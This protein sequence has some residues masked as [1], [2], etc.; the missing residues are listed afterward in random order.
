M[1]VRAAVLAFVMAIGFI[2]V[3]VVADDSVAD[4]QYDEHWCYGDIVYFEY[5]VVGSQAEV[6]WT[7][8]DLD[9]NII[10]VERGISVSFDASEYDI[11]YVEQLVELNGHSTIKTDKVNLMHVNDEVSAGGDGLFT[12]AFFDE[13]GGNLVTVAQFME[14]SVVHA[15]SGQSPLFIDEMPEDPALEGRSFQGWYYADGD[16]Q[17]RA[18]DPTDPVISDMEVYAKWTSSGS[19][20][21]GGSGGTVV[22]GGTHIVTFECAQGLT[23]NVVS[24]GSSSVSFTVSVADGYDLIGDVSVTSTGGTVTHTADGQY[25]LSGISSNIVVS[26][27]GNTVLVDDDIT[28][29]NPDGPMINN[30]NDYTLYAILLIILAI[31]CIALAVYIMRTRGSRV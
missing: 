16:G 31:I 14:S 25:I 26:I 8:Y 7:I 3:V 19:G 17:E 6:T 18:F 21:S 29:D 5:G 9:M 22:I 27:T 20:D 28:G 10:D 13:K 12:V 1:K 15:V 2:S 4:S 23:Y 30:G 24:T 11:I